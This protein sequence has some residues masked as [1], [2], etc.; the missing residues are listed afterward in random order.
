[1]TNYLHQ[2]RLQSS[3]QTTVTA[4][5]SDLPV[6]LAEAKTHLRLV[7]DVLDSAVQLQL[8]SAVDCV[9]TDSGRALRVSHTVAQSYC[10]WPWGKVLLDRQPVKAISSVTYYD[11]DGSSQTVSSSNYRLHVAS[12]ACGY[13]EF[14]VDFT[15]PALDYRDDAVTIA[16]TAGYALLGTVDPDRAGVPDRARSAILIKLSLLFGNLDPR[17]VDSYERSYGDLVAALN[18]GYYR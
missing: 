3:H 13:L 7:D 11:T 1:M 16:Y 15:R 10:Q 5:S 4:K 18:P 6:T 8:E 17:L 14:D 2:S 9:E 12:D